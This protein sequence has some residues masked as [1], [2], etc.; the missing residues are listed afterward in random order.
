[1]IDAGIPEGPIIGKLMD[2]VRRARLDGQVSTKQEELALAKNR[3]P[4]FLTS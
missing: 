4:G 3:L 2:V 1:L